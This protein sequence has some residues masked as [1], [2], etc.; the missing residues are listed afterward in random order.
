M[1]YKWILPF[2]LILMCFQSCI[3]DKIEDLTESPTETGDKFYMSLRFEINQQRCNGRQTRT[4]FL[5]TYDDEEYEGKVSD[6]RV[7]LVERENPEAAVIELKN[8]PM[9]DDVTTEPFE[10]ERKYM[11]GYLLYVVANADGSGFSPD[12][13]SGKA[14]CGTYAPGNSVACAQLWKPNNFLMVNENKEAKDRDVYI[15][16]RKDDPELQDPTPIDEDLTPNGGIPI[17]IDDASHYSYSNPYRVSVSLE[18][19]AAKI[20]VDCSKENFDFRGKKYKNAF[21]DVR[22]TG[23]ALVN[24]ANRFNLVQQ[25]QVACY[26]GSKYFNF[27]WENL[28]KWNHI[29]DN[30]PYGYPWLWAVTPM[31]DIMTKPSE[32]YY[33][34]VTDF[35]DWENKTLKKDADQR[36]IP[37]N[38]TGSATMYC[39]ENTSPLYIDFMNNFDKEK[40]NVGG[41]NFWIE[42]MESG[43]RN[44]VTG[45]LF[46]VRAKIKDDNHTNDDLIQDPDNGEWNKVRTRVQ[47]DDSYKTFYCYDDLVFTRLTELI[48]NKPELADKI[49]T[50]S[51]VKELRDAGVKVYED[52]YMYYM[53]WI[54]DHN[55]EYFWNYPDEKDE[56][57]TFNY[58][59]VLRNTRYEVNVTEVNEIGMD[60]PGREILINS[61]QMLEG[62]DYMLMPTN[63]SDKEKYL[64]Y[65]KNKAL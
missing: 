33:N 2:L 53:Y 64:P 15:S 18:R 63:S 52:G 29:P 1:K 21:Y 5:P 45:V 13:S 11:H 36:F 47:D 57:D 50:A 7:F 23:V 25:W 44:R 4:T 51:S 58:Y 27:E 34:Q 55:Y 42:T 31:S 43:M 65:L 59:A 37:I 56:G 39:L 54:V 16:M 14:F 9:V 41:Y 28:R 60:L 22:V 46:R 40:D 35:T 48:S 61:L 30:S 19:V 10:I 32:I 17:E 49:S 12:L 62:E 26:Q 38:T 8:L 3:Y 6:F 20:V 24:G